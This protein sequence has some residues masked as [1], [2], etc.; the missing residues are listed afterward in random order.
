MLLSS[1]LHTVLYSEYG[2]V[3][4][5]DTV[6]CPHGTDPVEVT[7]KQAHNRISLLRKCDVNKEQSK[8]QS[9]E[10]QL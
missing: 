4:K 3:N 9:E 7:R 5:I 8:G 2:E 10:M 6:S 1:V